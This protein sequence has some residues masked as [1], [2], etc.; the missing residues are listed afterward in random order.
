MKDALA[1]GF[2]PFMSGCHDLLQISYGFLCGDQLLLKLRDSHRSI[3]LMTL[4]N[5]KVRFSL[6]GTGLRIF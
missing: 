6:L 5:G 1:P 3:N 4:S 2:L